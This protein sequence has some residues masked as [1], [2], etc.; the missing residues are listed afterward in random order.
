[1]RVEVE[2]RD[3]DERAEERR[4]GVDDVD[5]IFATAAAE[6]LVEERLHDI[7][8]ESEVEPNLLHDLVQEP[9]RL[10]S[11][12]RCLIAAVVEAQPRNDCAAQ[13]LHRPATLNR[14]RVGRLRRTL[15]GN[16]DAALQTQS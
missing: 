6:L 16:D 2:A 9:L 13:R 10:V 12:V 11:A 5:V 8:K 14:H 3:V 1:M 15:R 7:F 4:D